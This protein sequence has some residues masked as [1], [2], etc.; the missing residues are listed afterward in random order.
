MYVCAY[1]SREGGESGP[2]RNEKRAER[3]RKRRL[4]PGLDFRMV[5]GSKSDSGSSALRVV[6][7]IW[8]A[9]PVDSE[10]SAILEGSERFF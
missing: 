6:S 10:I 1:A 8:C 9:S 4:I 3:V 2:R 7:D 5:L